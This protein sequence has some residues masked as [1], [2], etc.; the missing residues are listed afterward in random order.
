MT[1]RSEQAPISHNVTV[2]EVLTARARV[3]STAAAIEAP[4]RAPLSWAGLIDQI[5]RTRAALRRCGIGSTDRIATV[6]P[7]GP[8]AA[9]AFLSIS[10]S[11]VAVPLNPAYKAAELSFHLEHLKV[12]AV[13]VPAGTSGH[14][15]D[16]ARRHA[17]LVIEL[18]PRHSAAGAFDLS[19]DVGAAPAGE[20]HPPSPHALALILQ[21]SGTTSQP[22]IVP[23]THSNICASA[24]HVAE[25]LS[26]DH[27]DRCL[28]LMPQ[29]HVHGLVRSLLAPLSAG[30]TAIVAPGFQALHVL[31]WI[32]RCKPTWYT[33]V[34]TIH[35]AI[36][37]QAQ[38]K[39]LDAIPSTLRFIRSGSAPLHDDLR[40]ALER[41]FHVPVIQGYGMTEAASQVASNPLPPHVRKPASIGLPAG[42]EMA[43]IDEHGRVLGPEQPGEIVVRGPNVMTGYENN[44]QA[45]EAAFLNGW[46]RTGDLGYRDSDGYYFLTG[47][48]RDLINRGGQ[49]ITPQEV[50]DVLLAH[51]SVA[52]AATFPVPDA[53]LGEAVAAAVVL[54]PDQAVTE[55][56][57]AEFAACRLA[58]FK[59]P[60]RILFLQELPKGPTGKVKRSMLAET[61]GLAGGFRGTRAE[62]PYAEETAAEPEQFVLGRV[63]STAAEVLGVNDL[64]SHRSFL[65]SGGDSVRA[66]L[67]VARLSEAF[68]VELSFLEV[69]YAPSLLSVARIITARVLDQVE[70]C[71]IE[72]ENDHELR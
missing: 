46:F 47:R 41:T 62:E 29:F 35:R 9:V 44:Q 61:L 21:T 43:V 32:E 49:K 13:L 53:R 33:A 25:W 19:C 68:R 42:P 20:W 64:D 34:P 37:E 3:R 14:V 38:K 22:K 18:I 59:I 12:R 63:V 65:E 28:V 27:A 54:R 60:E 69:F 6:L 24:N 36:I 31:D 15:V 30:G 58:F 51:P 40:E 71:Q 48:L 72:D 56:Q 10:C 45:T 8:E 11:A 2:W 16:V 7:D 26:L 52:E 5:E 70:S 1:I 4:D 50:D 67:F 39:G 23:L 66:M 55:R 57:L 17:C